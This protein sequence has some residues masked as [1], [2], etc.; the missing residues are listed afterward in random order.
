LEPSKLAPPAVQADADE[1]ETL[2]KN[3][4]CEPAGFGIDCTVHFVPF[5]PSA[6]TAPALSFPTAVHAVGDVQETPCKNDPGLEVGIGWMLQVV[7]SQR[8]A[9][10]PG[11]DAP[12]ATQSLEEGHAI[13]LKKLTCAPDGFG[14][15]CTVHFAPSQCSASVT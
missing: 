6:M 4:N 10:A 14:V 9:S 7:P 15:D 11:S 8:S 12:T 1:H 5:H 2:L 3:A 13:P